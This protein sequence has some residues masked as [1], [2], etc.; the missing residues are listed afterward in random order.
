MESISGVIRAPPS[1]VSVLVV[2]A[3][4]AGVFAALECWR[5]GHNVRVIERNAS[6]RTQGEIDSMEAA[7]PA[8]LADRF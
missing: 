6:A 7:S 4:P 1:G 5:K 3:G 2:G 8:W